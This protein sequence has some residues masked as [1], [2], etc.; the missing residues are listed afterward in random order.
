MQSFRTNMFREKLKMRTPKLTKYPVILSNFFLFVLFEPFRGYFFFLIC[1]NLRNLRIKNFVSWCLCGYEQKMSN[2][3]NFRQNKR[4]FCYNKVL[5]QR[6]T[7]NEQRTINYEQLSNEP[8]LQ[9]VQINVSSF[10]TKYC[11]DKL[12]C[13]HRKNEPN[14]LSRMATRY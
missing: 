14:L 2:E 9:K 11:E 3:P 5:Y 8:N 7:N 1:E 10:I 13:R 12:T 4:N 6:T